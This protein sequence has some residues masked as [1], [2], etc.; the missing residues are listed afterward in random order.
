MKNNKID[1][2]TP[3]ECELC[4]HEFFCEYVGF[5]CGSHVSCDLPQS[6]C[7]DCGFREC[8]DRRFHNSNRYE[9]R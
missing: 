8:C 1:D 6:E 4:S 3:K 7:C 2:F 9:S 5:V